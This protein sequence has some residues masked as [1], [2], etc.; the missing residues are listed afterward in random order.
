[1]VEGVQRMRSGVRVNPKPFVA[2]NQGSSNQG[3]SSQGSAN[4]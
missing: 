3:S 2:Q 4:R 1:V